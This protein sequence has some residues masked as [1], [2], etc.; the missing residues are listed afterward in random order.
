M[1]SNEMTKYQFLEG[2]TV[3]ILGV[4][5][6]EGQDL[7]GPEE[8][9]KILRKSGLHD[10]IRSLEWEILD[11]EDITAELIELSI[12]EKP[13]EERKIYKYNNLKHCDL[14][15]A[16]C[17]KIHETTK[18]IAESKHFCLT[19][20]GDHG[21]ATGTISGL[22]SVYPQLKIIWV[23]AHADINMPEDSPSGN[24][25]GMPVAH[26]L[27]W[28][29]EGS[30]PG[31]D[32]FKPCLKT[33]DIVYIGLRDL[34]KGERVNL[35]K[36]GIK[37]FTMDDVLRYG[38][39][40]VMEQTFQYFNKDNIDHPIHISFDIDSCDPSFAYGTGTKAKGGLL[41]R[42]AHY[43]VRETASTGKL[44]GLDM[45]EINPSLDIHFREVL[46]G[47]NKHIKGSETVCLGLELISSALGHRLL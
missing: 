41:Y 18:K 26:L 36:H 39:G 28:M 47:D 15:G 34:D 24:Y 5:V 30:V 25:H 23:D 9:P 6:K 3:S 1:V 44:I 21:I 16:V 7:E 22:K 43:I 20:G 38:I 19:L 27:G 33:E 40:G 11:H 12:S 29:E 32:W 35:K 14:I 17:H 37:C 4:S 10:V 13:E 31:F 2:N 42:E 8:A 46:H 45:V